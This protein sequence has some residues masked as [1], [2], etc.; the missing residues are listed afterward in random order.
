M[1]NHSA[2]TAL[3][4]AV[5]EIRHSLSNF[6]QSQCKDIIDEDSFIDTVITSLKKEK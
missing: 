3:V 4:N 6:V 5:K 1:K 2:D